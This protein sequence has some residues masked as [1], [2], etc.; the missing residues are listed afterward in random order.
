MIAKADFV[1]HFHKFMKNDLCRKKIEIVGKRI[2]H[3]LID[4]TGA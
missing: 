2:N 1:K 4:E 3:D